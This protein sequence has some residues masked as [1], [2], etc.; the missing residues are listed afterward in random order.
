[1]KLSRAIGGLLGGLGV[2]AAANRL[3]AARAGALEPALPGRQRSY[4]WRG[5]DVAYTEAGDLDDPDL[6]LLH[7]IHA[8]ASSREFAGVFDRLSEEYHV[9]APD[10]PG[11]GRSDRPAVAY[12]ASL[13]ERFVREFL[14][15]VA[16]EPT[17]VASSLT[18]SYAALAAEEVPVERLLLVCPTADTGPRRPWLRRLLR[19]PVVGT[20]VFNLV[21]SRPSLAWFDRRDAYADRGR[22]TESVL[23][24]QWRTAHQPNARLAPASFVGGYLDP[25]VN[26]DAVLREV[27]ASVMLAWGRDATITSLEYGRLLADRA[28]VR[29]VVFDDARLLPHDEHPAAFTELVT[30]ELPLAEHE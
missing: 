30:G 1:M 17:V 2:T 16:D 13:Y 5:F 19:T 6:V 24:Y 28:D 14:A 3:L 4:R 9:V 25:D 22:A 20:G 10:L 12:T 15:D 11:F 21:V 27:D 23:D 18:G 8:A 29:L 26:L 7:G